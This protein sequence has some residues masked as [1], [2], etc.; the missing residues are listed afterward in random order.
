MFRV[1]ETLEE[2]LHSAEMDEEKEYAKE[3]KEA[4]SILK[5]R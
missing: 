3:L 5:D 2:E 4:I 1:I